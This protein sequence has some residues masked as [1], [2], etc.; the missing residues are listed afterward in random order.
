MTIVWKEEDEVG[1]EPIGPAYL[2]NDSSEVK[3]SFG[4]MTLKDARNLAEE[5]AEEFEEV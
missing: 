4:W 1:G 3:Q 5:A 2:V